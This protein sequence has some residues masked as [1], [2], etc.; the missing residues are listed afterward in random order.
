MVKVLKTKVEVEGRV[1][2]EVVVIDGEL[3]PP[4]DSKAELEIVGKSVPRVDGAERVTGQAR[5]TSDIVLPGLLY[6]R[7]LR[8]PHP[9]ARV[10]SVDISAAEALAGVRAVICADNTPPI[11]WFAA[12]FLF[13]L[14]VRHVGD[15]VAAVA[16]DSYEIAADALRLIKVEYEIL[17]HIT[18][19]EEAIAP[20][21]PSVWVDHPRNLTGEGKPDIY[22]RGDVDKAFKDA[23]FVVQATFRTPTALH[24]SLESHGSVAQWEGDNLT[25]WDSTQNVHGV[26]QR[27]AGRL[28]LP[29]NKVRVIKHYMGGGFGSKGGAGKYTV[30]AAL[31]ARK[32]GRPVKLMLNRTEENLVTGNRNSTVQHIAGAV[33][34]DGT[35]LALKLVCYA[36][37]GAYGFGG[38][39]IAGPV[40]EMYRCANVYT[41]SYSLYTNL[42]RDSAFRAPGFVEGNFALESLMDMMAEKVKMDPLEFRKKNYAERHPTNNQPYSSKG[43]R[44][45]YER[46]AE[47]IGW[48]S[49][50]WAD[51]PRVDAQNPE[52]RRGYGMASQIWGGGGGPPA[53]A[54]IKINSDGT[55]DVITGTQDIGTGTKT[56][57]SQ[58]AAE[59]LGFRLEDVRVHIGDTSLGLYA[60][61]SAGSMT[62][63]SMTTAVQMAAMDARKQLIAIA[64][65]VMRVRASGL[66]LKGSVISQRRGK[67]RVTVSE[68]MSELSDYMVVGRGVRGPND[69]SYAVNTFGCQFA[70][71]EVDTATGQVRVLRLVAVHE[72]GRVIN[73]MTITSQLYGGVTQGMG[74]GMMEHRVVD[75]RSGIVLNPNLTDYKIPT[76]LDIPLEIVGEMI[77]I[78]DTI[79]TTTGAKGIGEPPI[80]PTAPAIANAI[81]DATG[82]RMFE[83]PIT[84]DVLLQALQRRDNFAPVEQPQTTEPQLVPVGE[85]SATAE[86]GDT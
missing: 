7:I 58:V 79:A 77:D 72:S 16:A 45:A 41:E 11:K 20:E 30:I 13:D 48:H 82:V 78:P 27:V 71:V 83:A 85:Q 64:A 1:H 12:S 17:P 57:L 22:R 76:A 35:L 4:W 47:V 74:F 61:L 9:H 81:Y 42:G 39:P 55:A 37:V 23:D 10:K 60:P 8:S 43:L 80:V 49:R 18:A 6:A 5:Y 3:P 54:V 31:L 50:A 33:R 52:I 68:L 46:G 66:E 51:R 62:V 84:P 59:A 65:E 69:N 32:A 56:I 29:L 40:Q 15:E 24:N 38:M 34:K 44:Q 28:G 19:E 67:K 36:N 53:H 86:G 21:S 26:Q 73:P 70:E 75:H 25:I 2:E 14:T 63:P